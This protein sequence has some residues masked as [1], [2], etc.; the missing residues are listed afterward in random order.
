MG[1][2]S[3]LCGHQ[4][5]SLFSKLLHSCNRCDHLLP[6]TTSWPCLCNLPFADIPN[7][8]TDHKFPPKFG[9]ELAH[10]IEVWV[11]A[12][13][14]E[15]KLT[16]L[17]L[18][19]AAGLLIVRNK[20][21]SGAT[22]I[23]H[24]QLHLQYYFFKSKG[25]SPAYTLY[26]VKQ[27]LLSKAEITAKAHRTPLSRLSKVVSASRQNLLI[28]ILIKL[29]KVLDCHWKTSTRIYLKYRDLKGTKKI[30]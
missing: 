25:F 2:E 21:S 20:C 26:K 11:S 10:S 9:L 5:W 13:W 22:T 28:F 6:V 23:L 12:H 3:D 14:H 27:R 30:K 15:W 18:T 29:I 8:W 4:D 24:V 16:L 1:E 19:L 17:H 7:I